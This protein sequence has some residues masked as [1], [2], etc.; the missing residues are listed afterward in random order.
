MKRTIP[1]ARTGLWMRYVGLLCLVLVPAMVFGGADQAPQQSAGAGE[2][3]YYGADAAGTKYSALDQIN[4]ENVKDLRI[5]WRWKTDNL[6]PKP[7]FNFQATPLMVGGVLYTTA[8]SRRDV[9]A[10]DAATGETLWLYRFDEGSRGLRAPLRS[11]SGRGVAYWSDGTNQ[12]IF[13]VTQGYHLIQLDAKTGQPVRTFGKDGVI[14][15][16]EEL[17]DGTGRPLPA[18]GQIGWN[19][20]PIVVRGV[21]VVGAALLALAPQKEFPAGF[22]RGFDVRTGKRLWI[23]RTIPQGRELGSETWEKE[24]WRYTGNTGVWAPMSADEELGHVYLPVETP[25]NDFYGGHRL[26]DNLFAESLVSL[27]ARTGKMNWYYQFIHHGIWD[28]DI[29]TAPHLVDVNVDGK[30]IKAIAQVTKQAFTYVLN[31]QTGQPVWP[32]E[33]RPVPKSD[34]PGERTA[35]TQPFPS[36]PAPF[37]RQGVS[38]DDLIDFT[39]QI[40]AEAVKIAS[41]YKLGPI[42]TPPIVAGSDG[43]RGVLML[44]AATGG[45]NWQGGALDPETG[46]LYVA[47]VTN[48]TVLAVSKDLKRSS[49]D[50]SPGGSG[51]T[52]AD[53]NAPVGCGAMGPGGLPLVKPPWGRITAINLNTGDHV[54]MAP[55]SDTPECVKNHPWLKGVSIPPTGKPERSGLMVTKTLVFSGEGSGLLAVPSYAGGPMLRAHDKLTGAVLWEFQL[56]ANQ[57]GIPMT[58]MVGGKQYLVVAVG[59]RGHPAELIA[60]TLP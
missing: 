44:P 8:G 13:H 26:G 46:I 34:V 6:G 37:D 41:A 9:A 56:P 2:W 54:W 19:S 58:Y 7:D 35:S 15:L 4:K 24:S 20:P 3:R 1:A 14:D 39:P 52:P 18:D 38:L 22:V 28:W 17:H 42:F 59:G 48:P 31:R 47:S 57:S 12:R 45:A 50:F 40:R 30:R 5:E 11:A 36:K 43:K 25:T 60:L 16:Y 51:T 33:E 53:P 29:P 10:I 23:F 32:I 55:N 21:V 49:M 27:D